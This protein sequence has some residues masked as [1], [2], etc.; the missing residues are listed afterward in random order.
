MICPLIFPT[1]RPPEFPVTLANR[2]L[3]MAALAAGLTLTTPLVFAQAFDAVRLY[4]AA[5]GSDGGTVG[6]AVLATRQY[7]GSDEHRNLLVPLLDYQWKNG[8]FAGTTN[9][10]GVNLSSRQ[11]LDY[12]LRVTAD[13]GRAQSRSSALNGMGDIDAKPE[14]GGF[15]N[16]ALNPQ[17]VLTSSLRYGSGNNSRGMLLDLGAAYARALAPQ[18]RLG[19]GVAATFAN[20]EYQ[21]SYFGVD[22][23]QSLSSGY[24]V[25]TPGAGLRD[26]RAN[27][28]V[29]YQLNPRTAITTAISASSLRGDAQNSPLTR[30]RDSATGIVAVSYGF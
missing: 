2:S 3:K 29:T 18:W 4:G 22:A 12:G 7:Q 13:L 9:G 21:Q 23:V 6:A 10:I 17:M 11:D 27:V 5:P 20:A 16:Y 25:Y 14:L 15:F 26:V 19:L 30:Q 28:S 8:W 1:I 24:A